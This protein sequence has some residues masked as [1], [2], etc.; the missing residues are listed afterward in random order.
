MPASKGVSARL[1]GTK[2]AGDP[3]KHAQRYDFRDIARIPVP[4]A[5][6]RPDGRN[7]APGHPF[8]CG[9]SFG[10]MSR[11]GGHRQRVELLE[12]TKLDA[13]PGPLKTKIGVRGITPGYNP[14]LCHDPG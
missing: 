4:D 2:I 5:S 1:F 10:K 13:H 3:L 11:A 14:G 9:I 6:F 8:N 7:A 12:R